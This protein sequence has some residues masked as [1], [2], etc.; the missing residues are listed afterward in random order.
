MSDTS[1]D[2]EPTEK[3]RRLE[4]NGKGN[5]DHT[6]SRKQ[7]LENTAMTKLSITETKE[8]S[9]KKKQEVFTCDNKWE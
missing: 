9:Q 6:E 7:N 4:K 3:K 5:L 1:S 8:A 2:K